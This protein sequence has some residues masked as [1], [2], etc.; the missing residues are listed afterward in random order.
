MLRLKRPDTGPCDPLRIEQR[1]CIPQPAVVPFGTPIKYAG[2]IWVTAYDGGQVADPVG[3]PIIAQGI[4]FGPQVPL[5]ELSS[6]VDAGG[7][8]GLA[9]QYRLVQCFNDPAN[10]RP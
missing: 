5:C 7:I 2:K 9:D 10:L 4:A 1:E 8:A 3:L 6:E